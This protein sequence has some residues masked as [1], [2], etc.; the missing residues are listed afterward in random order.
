MILMEESTLANGLQLAFYD[1]SRRL[2]GDRWLV[3]LQCTAEYP[4]TATLTAEF[5]EPDEELR[6][7]V[8]TRLGEKLEFTVNRT[9]HFIDEHEKEQALAE[10]SSRLQEHVLAYFARPDFPR[11]LLLDACGKLREEC[12]LS[13]LRSREQPEAD[14]DEGP[15]DFS[16]LFRGQSPR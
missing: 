11:R 8:L 1:K 15:A 2:A 9:R 12:R 16:H 10:L 7:E 13:R 4:V 5:T 6:A 14:D 3:E